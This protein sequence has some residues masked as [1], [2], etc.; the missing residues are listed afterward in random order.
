MANRQKKPKTPK[1]K[2][3][4]TIKKNM[5]GR[6]LRRTTIKKKPMANRRMTTSQL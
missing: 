6:L 1:K 5:A 4:T 2:G 3:R